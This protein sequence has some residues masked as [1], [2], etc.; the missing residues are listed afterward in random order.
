MFWNSRRYT[1][2]E[3][4]GHKFAANQAAL[5]ANSGYPE[6]TTGLKV[7]SENSSDADKEF[8]NLKFQK[9]LLGDNPDKKQKKLFRE[10]YAYDAPI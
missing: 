3:E 5:R 7:Y 10:M 8:K 6:L 1:L 9:I 2:D 4:E